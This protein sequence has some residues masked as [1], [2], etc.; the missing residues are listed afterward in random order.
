MNHEVEIEQDIMELLAGMTDEE[1]EKAAS[2]MESTARAIRRLISR[3]PTL[4]LLQG[5]QPYP[6]FSRN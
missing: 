3:Q 6:P 2:N 1:K 4:S 5:L